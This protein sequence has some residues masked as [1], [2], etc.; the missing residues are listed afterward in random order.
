MSN[1]QATATDWDAV[2]PA[3]YASAKGHWFE[4]D[5]LFSERDALLQERDRLRGQLGNIVMLLLQNQFREAREI[6]LTVPVEF[7]NGAPSAA[8]SEK[9]E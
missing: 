1:R 6:A 8:L 3:L 2:K 5:S 4:L 9:G 7:P